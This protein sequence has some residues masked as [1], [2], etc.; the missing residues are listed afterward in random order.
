KR[1]L[2][3]VGTDDPG[4]LASMTALARVYLDVKPAEAE[5]LLRQA[6]AI[7]DKMTPDDWSS[8]DT[9]SLLGA[10]LVGQKK[11]AEAEPFL[12]QGY[13]GLKVRAAKIPPKLQK[14][15]P[16]AV[17]RIVKLYEA[18]GKKDLADEWRKKQPSPPAAVPPKP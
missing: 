11:Y 3:N 10:S 2:A 16:E 4:T 15:V 17:E 7:R 1:R 13:E 8:F 14:R 6:M 9:R 18:W 5:P 12:L